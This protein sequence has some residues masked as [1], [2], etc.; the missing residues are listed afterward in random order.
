MNKLPIILEY[1][2]LALSVFCLVL[3]I[4]STIKFGLSV[5]YM[6]FALTVLAFIMFII[7][8]YKRLK[9]PNR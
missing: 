9:S 5:S 2:W 3:G 1:I 7:R 6:F 4:H 8:R